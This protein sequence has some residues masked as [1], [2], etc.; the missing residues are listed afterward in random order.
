MPQAPNPIKVNT[1]CKNCGC[2]CDSNYC[3]DC[4]QSVGVK[5]LDNKSFFIGLASGLSRI[6]R[7]FLYT[8]W[9][10]LINPWKVIRDYV[11]CRRV[12][13]VAPVSMLIVVCF[14]NAFVSGLLS[15]D[16]QVV[17]SEM[18]SAAAPVTYKVA[19]TVTQFLMNNMLARNLTIYIPAL[20]S[21]LIV[22]RK[23]GAKR[24]NLA[25][26]F[27]AMIYMTSSFLIFDIIISPLSI[28][29]ESL[30]TALEMTYTLLICSL[31][32]YH[33]FPL[34]SPK[35]RIQHFILYL[36]VSALIYLLILLAIALILALDFSLHP[37]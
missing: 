31:S 9:Q 15:S 2:S 21:I 17:T 20:L 4:G 26:Y 35:R 27:T 33:A 28:A 24:Y 30:Y 1:T 25:E 32:M 3:P 13:Y 18:D 29:S 19:L 8:A 14:L 6:N 23:A 16:S 12:R 11:Q 5:R 34:G 22:Y 37:N 10:L 36:L 7:G